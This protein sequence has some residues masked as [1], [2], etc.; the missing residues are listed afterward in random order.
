[1]QKN[2]SASKGQ[3]IFDVCLNAYGTLD[4]LVK[5]LD[6]SGD[7]GVDDVP[8]SGQ[9]YVY[10]DSLV[11][12]Q[13][14]NQAY[15]LSGTKYAT[16]I[17]ANGNYYTIN[18]DRPTTTTPVPPVSGGDGGEGGGGTTTGE[19][20]GQTQFKSS[21]DGTTVFTP[22][23]ADG[24]SMVGYRVIALEREI[25]PIENL[26]APFQKWTFNP[27]NGQ[28]TLHAGETVDKDVTIFIMY[29]KPV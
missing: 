1:M 16:M 14:V 17:G 8:A 21:A 13:A 7:Q 15:T 26:P 23:D 25:R 4:N 10:D 11:V 24:L 19:M 27:L 22:A 3:S 9:N 20:I 29:S 12:D 28:I 5:L 2:Y 6:D 18:Q